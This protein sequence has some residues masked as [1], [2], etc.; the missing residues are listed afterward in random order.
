VLKFHKAQNL[1]LFKKAKLGNTLR[2]A[3]SDLGYSKKLVEGVVKGMLVQLSK[4][5]QGE[6]EKPPAAAQKR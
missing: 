3:L 4:S 5:Q 1:G 2:W 6:P